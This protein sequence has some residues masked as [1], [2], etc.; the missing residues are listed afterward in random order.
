MHCNAPFADSNTQTT[1]P[2]TAMTAATTAKSFCAAPL[3]ERD[4]WNQR[5]QT[6][7]F[8]WTQTAN[9]FLMAEAASLTPGRALDLAAGE[10]RNAVWL[11]EQGWSVDAIDF[12]DVAIDKG[13]QLADARQVSGQVRFEVADLRTHTPEEQAYALVVVMYLQLPLAELAPILARAVR[14]VAPG[15]TFLLVGHD[16]ENLARGVGGPRHPD[17]LYTAAQ[18]TALIG[19][20]LDIRQACQVERLVRSDDGDKVALDC[21]VRGQR[22]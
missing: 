20:A 1:Q 17:M 18:V 13:R 3:L 16:S 21:L 4:Y 7:A 15:G 22:V 9:Q 2:D 14:A 6:K 19:D 10:G 12:S 8:I 5:Y 11:A